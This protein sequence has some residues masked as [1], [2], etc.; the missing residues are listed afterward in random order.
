DTQRLLPLL[1][2]GRRA[3]QN[4]ADAHECLRFAS[5]YH[6]SLTQP[7]SPPLEHQSHHHLSAD[8][9]ASDT[10]LRAASTSPFS[11]A[12]RFSVSSTCCARISTPPPTGVASREPFQML[13]TADATCFGA[14]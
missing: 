12:S 7:R 5:G 10:D 6:R 4:R 8:S 1:R 9:S 13:L 11:S 14:L 2:A 3:R